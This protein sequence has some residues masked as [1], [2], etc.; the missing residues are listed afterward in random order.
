MAPPAL[1]FPVHT[2]KELK[3]GAKRGCGRIRRVQPP[4]Y[5]RKES[6]RDAC[7]AWRRHEPATP[8]PGASPPRVNT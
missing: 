1:I 8:G 7:G 4:P 3:R 5:M 2:T 6:G